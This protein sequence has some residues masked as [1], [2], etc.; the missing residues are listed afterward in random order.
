MIQMTIPND[1]IVFCD[2]DDTL[3]K[4]SVNPHEPEVILNFYGKEVVRDVIWSH[5]EFVR[6]LFERGYF[7]IFQSGN[8]YQW[9]EEVV[10]KLKLV[11]DNQIGQYL[12]MTKATKYIDD[13]HDIVHVFGN[14]VF[15][16]EQEPKW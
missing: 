9:A 4:E 13:K 11:G 5:Y 15:L 1:K 2:I 7:I 10:N 12:I 3:I 14:R 16:E 8:G 6:S